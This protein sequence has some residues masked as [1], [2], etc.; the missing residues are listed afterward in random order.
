MCDGVTMTAYFTTLLQVRLG[1]LVVLWRL[2]QSEE[3][4]Q[5]GGCPWLRQTVV[6]PIRSWDGTHPPPMRHFEHA[7]QVKQAIAAAGYRPR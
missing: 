6:Q 3:R 5:E 2:H 1:R 7:S 4:D